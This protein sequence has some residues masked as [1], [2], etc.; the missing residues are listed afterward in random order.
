MTMSFEPFRGDLEELERMALV[1]YRDEYGLVS[2]IN[3]Y[4]PRYF[5]YLFGGLEQRDHLLAAYEEDKIMAF[6]A[7]IPRRYHFRGE[8]YRG[9]LGCLMVTRKEAFRRGLAMGLGAKALELF[10]KYNYDFALAF[11]D[12]GHRTS[13]MIKKL[14]VAGNRIQEIKRMAVIFRAL[15]LGQL[16]AFDGTRWYQRA[17]MN[18]LNLDKLDAQSS[19]APIRLYQP[20]DLSACHELLDSYRQKVTLARVFEPEELAREL[21]YPEVAHTLVWE[22]AGKIRGLI[23]WVLV[24][25]IARF[26]QP[27]AWLN[28]IYL[29]GLEEKDQCELV[30]SF[31]LHARAQK[32]VAVLEWFKN[33]YPRQALW[34]NR[35]VPYPRSMHVI[36]GVFNPNLDLTDIPDMFEVML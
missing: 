22:E 2:Y 12:S 11:L 13:Q 30:R 36:A 8:I 4:S 25:H 5:D 23:N 15:D 17:G 29:E 32:A 6:T 31:L 26:T 14:K 10:H 28:H 16:F 20:R 1:S 34:K 19:P 21:S 27:W 18:F 7:L 9:L 3:N 35:F 24:E 33:Y